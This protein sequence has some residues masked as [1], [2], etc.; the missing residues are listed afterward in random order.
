ME[1]ST[2]M[3]SP[4]VTCAALWSLIDEIKSLISA[5]RYRSL[6]ASSMDGPPV[7]CRLNLSADHIV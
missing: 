2:Q 7:G 5:Q 1:S 6:L 4:G 3:V